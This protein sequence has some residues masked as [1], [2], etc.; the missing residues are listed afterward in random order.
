LAWKAAFFTIG[1]VSIV[2]FKKDGLLL[3]LRTPSTDK[4]TCARPRVLIADDHLSWLDRVTALLS[5]NFDLI[6][7]A[8]NGQALVGE[9]RRLQPDLIVLDITM[10]VLN[11]IQAAHDIRETEPEIKLV[12]LTVHEEPEYIRAC[13]A[14]GCMGYVKKSRLGTDLIPAIR[15]A[16][17]GRTFISPSVAYQFS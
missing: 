12:F 11:G 7:T 4:A 16:L 5:S 1:F 13:F 10:P 3:D 15:E 17:S 8:N 14:E 9:A 6:G 2:M